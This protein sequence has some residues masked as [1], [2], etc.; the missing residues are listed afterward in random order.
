MAMHYL[1]NK[2]NSA[3]IINNPTPKFFEERLI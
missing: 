3:T 2:L 1:I